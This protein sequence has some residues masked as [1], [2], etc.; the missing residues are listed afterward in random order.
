MRHILC[1]MLYLAVLSFAQTASANPFAIADLDLAAATFS[2]A[3]TMTN[4]FTGGTIFDVQSNT[5]ISGVNTV[6][7]GDTTASAFAGAQ[8][9]SAATASGAGCSM[10]KQMQA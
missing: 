1:V 4:T 6:S 10:W 8:Q 3:F 2:G 9:L 5:G 7:I